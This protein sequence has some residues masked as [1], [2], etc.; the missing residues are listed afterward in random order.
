MNV[1]ARAK[2]RKEI[3]EKTKNALARN[4]VN[5]TLKVLAIRAREETPIE[6]LRR[7]VN[8]Y[9]FEEESLLMQLPNIQAIVELWAV[10]QV[11]D[12]DFVADVVAEIGEGQD[13]KTYNDYVTK[14]SLP[15]N[16]F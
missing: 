2:L 9:E 15:W 10:C 7:L 13:A 5:A 3:I 14:H 12:V 8:F 1:K 4:D 6:T 11:Y 16:K